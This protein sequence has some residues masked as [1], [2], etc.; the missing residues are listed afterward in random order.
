MFR[1]QNVFLYTGFFRLPQQ[2]ER[3]NVLRKL[4]YCK[5]RVGRHSKLA[6]QFLVQT[7]TFLTLKEGSIIN[8]VRTTDI[9]QDGPQTTWAHGY[10]NDK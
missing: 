3:P 1:L 9:N 6:I 5:N 2:P 8:C 4:Y 7:N 10:P